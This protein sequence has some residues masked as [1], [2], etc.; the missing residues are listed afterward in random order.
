MLAPARWVSLIGV[1]LSVWKF[2][3]IEERW[4]RQLAK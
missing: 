2:G 3:R 4:T 1:A